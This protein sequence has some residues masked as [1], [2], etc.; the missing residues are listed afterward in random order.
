MP[1]GLRD[2]GAYSTGYGAQ[3]LA[4]IL[5]V[6]DRYPN[7]DPTAM[8]AAVERPPQHPVHLVGDADDLRL[9]RVH[10]LL[11]AAARDPAPRLAGAVDGGRRRS[12]RSSTGSRRSSPGRRPR[13]SIASSR[14][15]SATRCTCARSSTSRRIRSRA[16]SAREG[17]YPLDVVLPGPERQNRWKTGFRIFLAIPALHRERRARLGARRRRVPHVVRRRSRPAPRRGAC[18]TSRRTRSATRRSSTRTRICSPSAYPHASPLEGRRAATQP[19][20][21]NPREPARAARRGG[22]ARACSPR[23]GRSA[24]CCCGGRA[25]PALRLPH[26]DEHRY[27][28]RGAAAPT[29]RRTR[30]VCARHLGA[31]DARRA[32][33]ARRVRAV[34]GAVGRASRRP[35]GWARGCCSGCSASRSSGPCSSRSACSRLWWE[36]RHDLDARRLRRRDLRRTGSRSAARSSSSASRSRSSWVSPGCSATGGGFPRRPCFIGLALLFAFVNPYLA[37]RRTDWTTRSSAPRRRGSSGSSTSRHMPVV[38][39]NVHDVT[40]LPN[41]EA[42]GLGPS[43]RVV[44]WDTHRRAAV[45]DRGGHAS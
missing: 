12:R 30:R 23:R 37:R 4:Y 25:C 1:K 6:T 44:L 14:A 27:F 3:V 18:G 9:S 19:R 24:A 5:L 39:Q 21:T 13:V 40:S 7:A 33:G 10:R 2:A 29:R 31:H 42:T 8:L 34:R 45:H 16:S 38:V 22:H 17:R 15:T 28:S 32:R 20:S 11:P 36:R 35:A 43:R 26:L 41:A